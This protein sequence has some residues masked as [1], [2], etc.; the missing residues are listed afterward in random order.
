VVVV[1][2]AVMAEAAVSVFM[3]LTATAATQVGVR[4]YL[5]VVVQGVRYLQFIA[6]VVL[7]SVADI[8]VVAAQVGAVPAVP[9]VAAV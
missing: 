9:A 5:R 2:V 6:S 7:P 3:A 1:A 8:L 4:Q